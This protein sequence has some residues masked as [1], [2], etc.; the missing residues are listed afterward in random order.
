[1]TKSYTL[2]NN[3]VTEAISLLR[4]AHGGDRNVLLRATLGSAGPQGE[5]LHKNPWSEKF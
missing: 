4:I 3:C 2:L 1:M 5:E